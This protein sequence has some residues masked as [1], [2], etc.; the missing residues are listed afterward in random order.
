MQV[1][2]EEGDL[3]GTIKEILSSGAQDIYV[4]NKSGG[5]EFLM[6]AVKEII[7]EISIESGRMRVDLPEGLLDL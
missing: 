6:P 1:Y 4:V 5:G 3:L 7:K 2:T